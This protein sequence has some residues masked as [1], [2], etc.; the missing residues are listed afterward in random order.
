MFLLVTNRIYKCCS[1]EFHTVKVSMDH[2][3]NTPTHHLHIAL[4]R[5]TNG[6]SLGAFQKAMLL[7]NLG[8]IG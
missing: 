4:T 5:S 1:Y 2:W 6:Q 7:Q 8:N 3:W